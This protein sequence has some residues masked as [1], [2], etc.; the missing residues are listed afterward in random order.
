MVVIFSVFAHVGPTHNWLKSSTAKSKYYNGVDKFN[1]ITSKDNR[2]N[3]VFL[4]MLLKT[5]YECIP[6]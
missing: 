6:L 1:T 3:L 2:C 4:P 5:K